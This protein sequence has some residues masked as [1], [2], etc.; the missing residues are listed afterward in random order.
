MEKRP[1]FIE[2]EI[3]HV[4]NRG[5][6][7]EAIFKNFGNYDYF[8]K[9]YH[10]YLDPYWETLT[11]CLMPTH[12][13]VMIRVK[14]QS[15]EKS[16]VSDFCIKAYSDFCNSYVQAFNRQHS[17]KGSLF[18]RNFKRKI[19]PDDVGARKLICYIHN[20]PVKD[21]YVQTAQEW[22]HSSFHELLQMN[23]EEECNNQIIS[24]FGSKKDFIHA[25]IAELSPGSIDIKSANINDQGFL[26]SSV[27]MRMP[28]IDVQLHNGDKFK[29][30]G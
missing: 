13:H 16:P 30:A 15:P 20:N 7:S 26:G 4:Y 12:F 24:R 27:Y 2:N 1:P 10:E 5:N 9:K 3:Y 17:R 18:M 21:G 8:L 19:V 11:W 23:A 29:Q 6:G 28:P 14:P 25:H 22:H